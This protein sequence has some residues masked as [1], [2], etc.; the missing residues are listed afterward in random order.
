MTAI[1]AIAAMLSALDL[2]GLI[3]LIPGGNEAMV[4]LISGGLA[5]LGTILRAVGDLIDDGVV[6]NSFGKL[7]MHW[8]TFLL[9]CG[10]AAIGSLSIGCA[11]LRGFDL[12]LQSPWGSVE[13]RDG[14]TVIT[15]MPI[16]FPTK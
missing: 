15:P 16:V 4:A 10:I 14:N 11:E 12:T 1:L 6:N 7:R 9:A 3:N 5:T 8:L 13:S 2:S